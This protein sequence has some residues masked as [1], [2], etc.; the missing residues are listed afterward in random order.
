MH[1]NTACAFY[2]H[3]EDYGIDWDAPDATDYDRT[4][5]V[6]I[7]DTRMPLNETSYHELVQ[8]INPERE[9]HYQGV[10]I[11]VETINFMN[12]HLQ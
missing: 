7:P 5:V 4:S 6:E 12:E 3:I 11:Y 1:A 8:R 2:A 9:S 10:D